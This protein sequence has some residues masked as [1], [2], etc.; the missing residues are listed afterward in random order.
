MTHSEFCFDSDFIVP[1]EIFLGNYGFDFSEDEEG[2][3]IR[4]PSEVYSKNI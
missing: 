2:L 4:F 3:L 1:L